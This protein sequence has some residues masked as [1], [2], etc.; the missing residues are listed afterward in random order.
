MPLNKETDQKLSLIYVCK[1]LSRGSLI[2]VN[3]HV[4]TYHNTVL[5]KLVFQANS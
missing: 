3:T 1:I 2:L 4:S 5:N